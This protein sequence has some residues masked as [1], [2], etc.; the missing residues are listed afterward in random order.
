MLLT[1]ELSLQSP[2]ISSMLFFSGLNS[3]MASGKVPALG[4]AAAVYSVC[5]QGDG[6]GGGLLSP[7][8]DS[9]VLPK[10]GSRQ[11]TSRGGIF[12]VTK[13]LACLRRLG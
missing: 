2:D 1:S 3:S 13:S 6:A 9:A 12:K 8:L 7:I 11:A 10:V 5:R 4:E